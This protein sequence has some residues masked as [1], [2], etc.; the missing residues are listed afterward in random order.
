MNQYDSYKLDDG[1]PDKFPCGNCDGMFKE[2]DIEE[3]TY[4]DECGTKMCQDL[5]GNCTTILVPRHGKD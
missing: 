4:L 2:N 5:C 3:I 1:F